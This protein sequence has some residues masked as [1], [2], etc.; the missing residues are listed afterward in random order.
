MTWSAVADVARPPRAVFFRGDE[1]EVESNG[2]C[3]KAPACLCLCETA[4]QPV[5]G[6]DLVLSPVRWSVVLHRYFGD[7]SRMAVAFW[8]GA[9]FFPR[10]SI[11]ARSRREFGGGFLKS[12]CW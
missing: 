11:N 9:V 2:G 6:P 5:R 8:C 4:R 1:S 10:F 3:G 7:G 12:V